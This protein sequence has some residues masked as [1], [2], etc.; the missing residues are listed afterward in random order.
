VCFP[1]AFVA[2][3]S[4]VRPTGE[5]WDDHPR[6]GEGLR[7]RSLIPLDGTLQ[8]CLLR[9]SAVD[10]RGDQVF[11]K[12]SMLRSVYNTDAAGMSPAQITPR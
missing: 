11:E 9:C 3:T 6:H 4:V 7:R 2:A 12:L 5:V 10:D 8:G 1:D